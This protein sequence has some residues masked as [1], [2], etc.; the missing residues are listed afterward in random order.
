MNDKVVFSL[1]ASF[2]RFVVSGPVVV[3][4]CRSLFAVSLSKGSFVRLGRC[5]EQNAKIEAEGSQHYPKC[6]QNLQKWS[7]T[8][9]QVTPESV[10]GR[11][12]GVKIKSRYCTK[13]AIFS[14]KRYQQVDAHI[15]ARIDCPPNM[16]LIFS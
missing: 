1:V 2:C 15:D 12:K 9:V 4:F 5:D 13:V 8:A 6:I 11:S 16:K 10:Q 14:Q 3:V 7:S